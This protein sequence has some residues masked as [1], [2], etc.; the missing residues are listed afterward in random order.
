VSRRRAAPREPRPAQVSG[1]VSG[2][3]RIVDMSLPAEARS[4]KKKGKKTG[5]TPPAQL[6]HGRGGRKA[7]WARDG[8]RRHRR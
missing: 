1:R 5:G 2:P 7:R 3:H 8:E 4:G 6:S